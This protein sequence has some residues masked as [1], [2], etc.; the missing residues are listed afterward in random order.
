MR[1]STRRVTTLRWRVHLSLAS[2]GNFPWY[3]W[4]HC[5]R[6]KPN[7][8]FSD[9]VKMPQRANEKKISRSIAK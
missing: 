1:Q 7:D 4:N 9:Y 8:I 5:N 6:D 3:Q 2:K